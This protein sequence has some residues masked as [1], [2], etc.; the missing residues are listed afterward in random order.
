MLFDGRIGGT[1]GPT[2]GTSSSSQSASVNFLPSLAGGS[3]APPVVSVYPAGQGLQTINTALPGSAA[4]QPQT[5]GAP[6]SSSIGTVLLLAGAGLAA[7]F[8]LRRIL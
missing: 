7:W 4:F 2:I 6:A 5:Y 1:T 3:S 8:L